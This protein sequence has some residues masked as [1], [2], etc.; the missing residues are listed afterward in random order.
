MPASLNRI[1]Y[2]DDSGHQ[3]SGLVVYGWI[4]FSPDGWANALESWLRMRKKLWREY[5]IP[6]TKELHT[7]NYV[8][9]RGRLAAQAPERYVHEGVT[10]WKDFGRDVARE[11]LETLGSTVGLQARAVYRRVDPNDYTEQKSQAYVDFVTLHLEPELARQ[12]SLA[13]VFMDGDGSDPTYRTAHRGLELASRRV[14]E[15]AIHMDSRTSQ[16]IQMA[17]LVAWTAA[18]HL[19]RPQENEFAWDWYATHLAQRD[20]C[21]EPQEI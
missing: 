11:C 12:N 14:I 17:D 2:V 13:L 21:R 15:D 7:T 19:D 4:E 10:Y 6:V 18:A 20:P 16:L 8:H 3:K 9:G 5:R 1:L